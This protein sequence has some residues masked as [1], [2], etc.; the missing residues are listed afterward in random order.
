VARAFDTGVRPQWCPGC[1]NYGVLA[2]VRGAL[3]E[4]GLRREEVVAVAGI[5]CHGRVT[6]YL[7]VNAFH[8]IH[9]RAVPVAEGVKL[10]NPKLT[11]LVHTGD[12]DAY[13]IGLS[14]LLHAARRNVGI[15]VIVHNNMVYALTTG[16]A[17]PTT[18]RG[19]RTRST[20]YGNPEEPFN[21]LLLLLASGATFVAKGFQRRRAAPEGAGEARDPAQGLR[22]H[23]RAPTVRHVLRHEGVDQGESLQARG[24]WPRPPRLQGGAG[25][26][27]G[28]G[29]GAARRA[30]RGGEAG[31]RGARAEPR[32]PSA[33]AEGPQGESPRSTSCSRGSSSQRA[34]ASRRSSGSSPSL[35]ATRTPASSRALTLPS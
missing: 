14:H 20:P 23:R 21:P 33:G 17:G 4:L 31:L 15:K 24:C 10:A 11:V 18:P 35:L 16:Q 1:G 26:E 29:A 28:G 3:A 32:A 13:A 27:L 6:E 25:E 5:G 2:A 30:L 19:L 34:R 7:D 12:G 22:R 9:G 8:A